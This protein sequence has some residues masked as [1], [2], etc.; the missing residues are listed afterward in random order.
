MTVPGSKKAIRQQQIVA[1][2]ATS[3]IVRISRLADRFGVSTET[4]RRDI[5]ELSQRG[6]IDRTYGGAAT[7]YIGFQPAV[8][9]RDRHAVIER[10]R[11][12][13]AAAALVKPGDVVMIDSGSTTTQFARALAAALVGPVTILTNSLSVA[14]ALVGIESIRVILCPGDLNGRE[15]GLYG[16]EAV[17]FIGRYYADLAFIGASGLTVDGPTDVESRA[18]SIKR[19]MVE[20]ASRTVLLVDSTKFDQRH[21]EVVCP[22]AQISDIVTDV[23]PKRALAEAIRKVGTALRIAA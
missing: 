6:I 19:A 10:S 17:A 16:P 13:R 22:L 21:L 4:A 5:E 8:T 18:C 1:E 11:I 3:P 2:L 9:E 23:S 12:G 15:R 14:T 7:R 20:R